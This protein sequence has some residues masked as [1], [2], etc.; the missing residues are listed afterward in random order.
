MSRLRRE[1]GRRDYLA[2]H[3]LARIFL[4]EFLGTLPEHILMRL[5]PGGRPEILAPSTSPPVSFSISHSDGL[6]M[7]ALAVGR[8]LGADVESVREVGPD[9]IRTGDVMLSGCER[10]TLAVAP[11]S[12]RAGHFLRIWTMK[13][14]LAK[15]TGLGLRLPLARLTVK[16]E[17]DALVQELLYQHATDHS[18]RWRLTTQ[19]LPPHHVAAVAVRVESGD[20][21]GTWFEEVTG[22]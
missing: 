4:A 9:P 11:E 8:E 13:E 6:A 18:A 20:E 7:C 3:A 16:S 2:A 1:D 19:E 12:E 21:A 14:A 17:G 10:D 22:F 15:A 5:A